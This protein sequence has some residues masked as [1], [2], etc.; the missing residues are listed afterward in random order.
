MPEPQLEDI[1]RDEAADA[2]LRSDDDAQDL[3]F[4]G[5]HGHGMGIGEIMVDE[6]GEGDGCDRCGCPDEE[7]CCP[8]FWQDKGV[9]P[10]WPLSWVFDPKNKY[11]NDNKHA[12]MFGNLGFKVGLSA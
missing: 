12:R 5:I 4:S 10:I 2:P 11:L 8:S 6:A 7:L 3:R 1:Y 9:P